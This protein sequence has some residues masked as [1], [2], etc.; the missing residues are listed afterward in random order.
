MQATENN[1]FDDV[2][3]ER[4][5]PGS[6]II[7]KKVK[8]Q[9]SVY[10]EDV[11]DFIKFNYKCKAGTVDETNACKPTAEQTN[12]LKNLRLDVNPKNKEHKKPRS[13][14]PDRFFEINLSTN[15]NQE[16]SS[17]ITSVIKNAYKNIP[18]LN[19]VPLKVVNVN[20]KENR[21][22]ENAYAAHDMNKIYLNDKY[23][24]DINEMQEKLT[25]EVESGF[26]PKGCNTA[27][28]I[29]THELGHLLFNGM[30]LR[31]DEKWDKISEVIQE[32][33]DSGELAKVSRY[34][35]SEAGNGELSEAAS[36]IFAS[37]FHTK[38]EDKEPVVKKVR[39]ILFDGNMKT[40]ERYL[41][42]VTDFIKLNYKC[43]KGTVDDT[44]ACG[45]ENHEN[46][47]TNETFIGFKPDHNYSSD[48][49][50]EIDKKVRNS[51]DKAAKPLK[52][53]STEDKKVLNAY[54]RNDYININNYLNGNLKATYDL[55]DDSPVLKEQMIK[56]EQ[57]DKLFVGSELTEPLTTY[58][59]IND[60]I[61]TSNPDL[62][63]A[64]D[65]PGSEIEFPCFISTSALPYKANN[66][67]E[68]YNGRLVELQLP[69]NTKALFIAQES[70]LPGE[71]EVLINRGTKFE[72]VETKYTDI[73]YPISPITKTVTPNKRVKIT[74]IKAI[75]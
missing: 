31:G 44:N 3:P 10:L 18:E 30:A 42:E 37:I 1:E 72:V 74:T 57:M 67:A 41:Y 62:R 45:L 36:E 12:E 48:Q 54:S 8:K 2:I 17:S 9:N 40:N 47:P 63:D 20:E 25:K 29:I 14:T 5:F 58:R 61:M 52:N 59:G 19:G 21:D 32:A 34:A 11:S 75:V 68:G 46:K 27:E 6:I 13:T 53:F 4:F 38:E 71:M 65:S 23:F 28:S 70:D 43:P 7:T 64:L 15:I 56:V 50:T 33:K 39:D 49:H 16:L 69:K 73:T 26:H 55:P 22:L 60:N 66:F 35:L 51:L 24:S